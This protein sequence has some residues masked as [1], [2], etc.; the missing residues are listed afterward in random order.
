MNTY[1]VKAGGEVM[2]IQAINFMDAC[3]IARSKTDAT[4]QFLPNATFMPE[5]MK[6]KIAAIPLQVT[7][8]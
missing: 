8:G 1:T 4:L 7:D 2:T 3:A 5:E 6:R